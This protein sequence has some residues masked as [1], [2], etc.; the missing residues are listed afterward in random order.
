M[1]ND[2]WHLQASPYS[3]SLNGT[4]RLMGSCKQG[5]ALQVNVESS[6]MQPSTNF[7]GTKSSWHVLVAVHVYWESPFKF[8][9]TLAAFAGRGL[10]L[11]RIPTGKAL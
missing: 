3:N 7:A 11:K 5:H 8:Q 9:G 2:R 1:L 4:V 10:K 6:H